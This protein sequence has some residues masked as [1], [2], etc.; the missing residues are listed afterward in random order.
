MIRAEFVH[1]RRAALVAHDRG[2]RHA[3]L[4]DEIVSQGER[5]LEI[6]AAMRRTVLRKVGDC[7]EGEIGIGDQIAEGE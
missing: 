5:C 2:W 4:L 1:G 6:L 3:L 7:F